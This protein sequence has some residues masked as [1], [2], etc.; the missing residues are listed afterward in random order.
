MVSMRRAFAVVLACVA[1][2]AFV[3]AE[4]TGFASSKPL[5][6]RL[7][8]ALAVPHVSAAR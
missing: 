1:G 7:A 4:A 8:Q 3:A 6:G 2:A 5:S